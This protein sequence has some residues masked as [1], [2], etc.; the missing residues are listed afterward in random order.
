MAAHLSAYSPCYRVCNINAKVLKH[1]RKKFCNKTRKKDN[2]N[3]IALLFKC[4]AVGTLQNFNCSTSEGQ[5]RGLSFSKGMPLHSKI[6]LSLSE[7]NLYWASCKSREEYW[8]WKV[9]KQKKKPI[10]ILLQVAK[11]MSYYKEMTCKWGEKNGR[12]LNTLFDLLDLSSQLSVFITLE[13]FGNTCILSKVLALI[14]LL[15]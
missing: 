10:N 12:D 2:K 11:K 3:P 14:Y 4:W 1:R 5:E 15:I 8:M 6:L 9:L 13:Q 7:G